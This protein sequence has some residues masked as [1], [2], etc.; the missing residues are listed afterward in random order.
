MKVPTKFRDQLKEYSRAGFKATS[1]EP[2]RG[3][4]W[5]VVFERIGPAI[6]T[7]NMSDPRAIKNNIAEF[8]RRDQ[9]AAARDGAAGR[10]RIRSA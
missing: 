5:L 9:Q 3:S 8:R 4:H 1:M 2:R 7:A 10:P 6:L